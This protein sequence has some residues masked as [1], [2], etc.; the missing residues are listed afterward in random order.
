[1]LHALLRISAYEV[2]QKMFEPLVTSSLLG[3]DIYQSSLFTYALNLNVRAQISDPYKVTG[4]I[5]LL[6]F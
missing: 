1:M 5:I 3:P 2:P 4:Q 6:I